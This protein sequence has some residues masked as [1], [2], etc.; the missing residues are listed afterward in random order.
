MLPLLPGLSQLLL[1]HEAFPDFLLNLGPCRPPLFL[2]YTLPY[3]PLFV[4]LPGRQLSPVLSNLDWL[5]WPSVH[6]GAS[7]QDSLGEEEGYLGLE[8]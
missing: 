5:H 1:L 2:T 8:G 4:S 7:I 3:W 6:Q